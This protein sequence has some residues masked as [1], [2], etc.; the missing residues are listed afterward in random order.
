MTDSTSPNLKQNKKHLILWIM[1]RKI[2]LQDIRPLWKAGYLAVYNN[3][4]FYIY[5]QPDRIL[6]F[7]MK[8][9]IEKV[10]YPNEPPGVLSIEYLAHLENILKR[11]VDSTDS[12]ACY[13][14]AE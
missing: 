6:I 14:L 5:F 7:R 12:L 13:I 1:D 8:A 2:D 4:Q 11:S 3:I 9:G 10:G